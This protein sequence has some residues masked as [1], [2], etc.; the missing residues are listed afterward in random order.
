MH[1]VPAEDSGGEGQVQHVHAVLVPALPAEP[2]RG[3]GG[4]CQ[5]AGGMGLPKVPRR[6]QLQQL[7]QGKPAGRLLVPSHISLADMHLG[8]LLS[9]PCSMYFS[10]LWGTAMGFLI[11][12]CMHDQLNWSV[13]AS[14]VCPSCVAGR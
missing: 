6:L 4:S 7:P 1:A 10:R 3:G 8:V 2:L 9:G 14:V 13:H 5:P 12:A 11:H